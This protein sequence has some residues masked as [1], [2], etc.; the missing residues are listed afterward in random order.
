[1]ARSKKLIVVNT[2]G[3][4]GYLFCLLQWLW[5][6]LLYAPLL[7]QTGIVE[8]ILPKQTPKP[9]PVEVAGGEPSLALLIIGVVITVFVIILTIVV[10]VRLPVA[11]GKTGKKVTQRTVSSVMPALTHHKKLPEKQQKRLHLT[12]SFLFK[13]ILAIIPIAVLLFVPIETLPFSA[14]VLWTVTVFLA[15]M[16]AVFFGLQYLLVKLG[17]LDGKVV[18]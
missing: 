12:I 8:Q 13:T 3:T 4:L 11:I 5:A 10:L 18:W 6:G 2:V 9:A 16:T 7:A 14:N 15:A 1:M 17:K